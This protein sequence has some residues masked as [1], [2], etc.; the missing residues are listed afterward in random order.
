[1]IV[2]VQHPALSEDQ[3][4]ELPRSL[5]GPTLNVVVGGPSSVEILPADVTKA[6]GLQGTA[7]ALGLT[8]RDAIAFRDMPSDIP[9]L[10]WAAHGDS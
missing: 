8:R 10:Q 2:L 4:A 5:A 6:T 7:E 9:M 3:L 1:M